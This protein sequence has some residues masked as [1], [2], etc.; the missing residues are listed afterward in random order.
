MFTLADLLEGTGGKLV[1]GGAAAEFRAISIDSRTAAAGDLFVAFRSGDVAAIDTVIDDDT[2]WRFPGR[3]V[4]GSPAVA[5][6]EE[7][8]P[9]W[10]PW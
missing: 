7:R 4:D 8:P 10:P 1:A 3:H 9:R 6:Y 5:D 2:V